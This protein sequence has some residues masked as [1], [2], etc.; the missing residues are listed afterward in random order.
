MSSTV[1]SS[2]NPAQPDPASRH[3]RRNTQALAVGCACSSLGFT[4]C[5]P[6]IP[7]ILRDL[8]V[9]QNLE[10]WV[11]Y[12]VGGFFVMS[13]LMT[14]IW[15]GLADHY[16][17]RTLI[18]RAGFGMG[19][20]F[21]FIPLLPNVWA[22][23]GL[24]LVI[25]AANGYI[26]GALAM[27]AATTPGPFAG[28]ALAT[29]Q[30]GGLVGTALGPAFG[31]LLI[32]LLPRPLDLFW[33]ASALT[34]GAGI[35]ALLF[36]REDVEPVQARFQL[37]ILRDLA[38]CVR[39][40]SMSLLYGV[41]AI[42]AMTFLGSSTVVSLFTLE[43]MADGNAFLGHNAPFWIGAA[44]LAMTLASMAAAYGWGRVLDRYRVPTIL[45]L[46]LG[47]AAIGSATV[48]LAQNP[49][50]L[51]MSRA[52]LGAL[53]VGIQPAVLRLIKDYAPPGMVARAIGFAAA[54]QMVGNGSAPMLAG[55]LAT[56]IGLRGY[57]VVN[58]ALLVAV[59]ILWVLRGPDIG[60]LTGPS[61]GSIGRP[62]QAEER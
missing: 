46:T 40:P 51:T 19:L 22:L 15:G 43:M 9:T 57:L 59:L 2:E 37:T 54:V 4:C 30:M 8:G 48:P 58:T 33:M 50:Q 39:V 32:G 12:L 52:L 3:W 42:F 44:T 17:K 31:A 60:P 10:A 25:G 62:R 1:P 16:G 35:I 7:V 27:M 28:R 14:P 26:P 36:T 34:T 23:F 13:F 49:L 38:A 61:I 45:T 56:S 11:G 24:F 18:L 6:Y 5:W 55:L 21:F 29:V 53:T 20:S 41:N 47:T